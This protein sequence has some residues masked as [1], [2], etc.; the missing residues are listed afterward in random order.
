MAGSLIKIDEEIVSGAVA[1]VTLTGIDSTYD[2]YILKFN[3]IK[4]GTDTAQVRF[5]VVTGG[6]PDTSANY[7][8]AHLVPRTAA[9]FAN[10]NTQNGTFWIY[11]EGGTATGEVLNGIMYLFNFSN[12]SEYCYYTLESSERIS[13]T[14]LQGIAGGG[15]HTVAQACEGIKMLVSSGNITAGSL[16]LYGLSK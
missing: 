6:S 8:R 13:S 3:N 14:E 9:V 4:V 7:D 11:N 5:R 16:V 1:S 12:A 2:V 15:V 10:V